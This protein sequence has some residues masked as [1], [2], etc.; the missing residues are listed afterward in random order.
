[1]QY[2]ATGKES[3]VRIAQHKKMADTE[4]KLVAGTGQLLFFKKSMLLNQ[5]NKIS[6]LLQTWF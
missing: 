1:M 5:F 3:D 4:H 2:N 6:N